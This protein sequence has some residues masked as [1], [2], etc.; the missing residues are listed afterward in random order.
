MSCLLERY[1]RSIDPFSARASKRA[2][3]RP[4]YSPP[5]TTRTPR[6]APNRQSPELHRIQIAVQEGIC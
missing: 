6:I 5:A 2:V 1:R 4:H 3:I